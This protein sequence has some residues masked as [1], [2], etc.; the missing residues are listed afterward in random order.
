MKK[1]VRYTSHERIAKAMIRKLKRI[2]LQDHRTMVQT[3][4]L[5]IEREAAQRTRSTK[6]KP[7]AGRHR[8]R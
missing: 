3:L 7:A 2:A 6:P 4:G 5:L 1:R 8:K